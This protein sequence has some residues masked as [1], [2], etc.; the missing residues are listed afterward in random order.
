MVASAT[1]TIH[2]NDTNA[3]QTIM[4]DSMGYYRLAELSPGTYT[5]TV[6]AAGFASFKAQQV[7]VTVGALTDLSPNL[8]VASAGQTVVVTATTPQI[9]TTSSDFAPLVNHTAIAELPIQRPRWSS[10]ALL[11]PGVVNDSNGFGLLSFRGISTLLNN[12]TVDGADN[13]QAFFAEERGRTRISY[14]SSS[15]MIQEFQVN[16]SNYSAEYGRAAGGVVNTVT[17]SG[18]NNFHGEAFFNRRENDWGSRNPFALVS[19]PSPTGFTSLPVK[20]TDWWNR[21]GLLELE[22]RIIRDKLFFFVAYDPYFDRN[23]P[24]TAVAGS[25][26]AFFASPTSAQ[27]TTLSTNLGITSA[28]RRHRSLYNSDLAAMNSG[29]LGPVHSHR[30][31]RT[32]S[33]SP[34]WIGEINSKNHFSIE[35]FNRMRWASP[36]GIQT[37]V[38]NTDAVA[39]FGNDYVWD[40]WGVARLNTTISPTMLNEFRVQLGRDFEFENSQPPTQYEKQNLLTNAT[41]APGYVNRRRASRPTHL[42]HQRLRFPEARPPSWS[43]RS[44]PISNS[45]SNMRIRSLG[46]VASSIRSSSALTLVTSVTML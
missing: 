41:V 5:V 26:S 31:S 45:A 34:S 19:F 36:A 6:T 4:T 38:T 9:N 11:T 13:N 12:N 10:F 25:P 3:E 46:A 17:K 44:G 42:R 39:S 37:Q 2:N 29:L 27:I 40:T 33:S 21:A 32:S 7:I 30:H 22:G 16:T 14:S 15:V 18:T 1:V 35:A 28:F 24:G 8:A 23:F 43:V 20:P